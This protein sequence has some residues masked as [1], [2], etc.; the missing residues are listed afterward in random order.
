MRILILFALVMMVSCRPEFRSQNPFTWYPK[1]K[2]FFSG[3]INNKNT[4]TEINRTQVARL[5]NH[6]YPIELALFSDGKFY[7]YLENLG[8][9]TGT[10]SFL[11]GQ[12]KLYA[13]RKLFAMN[14]GIHSISESDKD[15]AVDFTDRFGTQYLQ[16]EYLGPM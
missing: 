9:G 5:V 1:D 6:A 14:I 15:I 12:L 10:W 8:D 7:Y 11:D 13:E 2:K 3:F 4:P 16:M